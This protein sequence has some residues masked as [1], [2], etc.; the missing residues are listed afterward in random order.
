MYSKVAINSSFSRGASVILRI[1]FF[2]ASF[3]A[4]NVFAHQAEISNTERIVID[5][6]MDA[7]DTDQLTLETE[8]G[9]ATSKKKNSDDELLT[10]IEIMNL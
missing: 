8:G 5:R 1:G 9:D 3:I 4:V 7:E 2:Y 10:S 6:P